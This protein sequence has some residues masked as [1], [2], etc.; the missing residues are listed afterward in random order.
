VL[1]DKL[2]DQNEREWYVA[3]AAEYGWSRN[4][5]L[6]QIMHQLH[7]RSR[8]ARGAPTAQPPLRR[9]ADPVVGITIEQKPEFASEPGVALTAA[10][11]RVHWLPV[12]AALAVWVQLGPAV[13]AVA[14]GSGTGGQAGELLHQA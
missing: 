10:N 14:A 11:G 5:L 8:R 13:P 2:N 12:R 6:N 4:V 7:T 1:L 3:A 9:Q